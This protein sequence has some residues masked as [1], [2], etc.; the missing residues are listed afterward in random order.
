METLYNFIMEHKASI[1]LSIPLLTRG[2]YAW[3]NN[4]GLLGVW[5]SIMYGTN[6]PK[7]NG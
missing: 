7:I 3:K 2:W 5:R 1:A 6:A 4:G